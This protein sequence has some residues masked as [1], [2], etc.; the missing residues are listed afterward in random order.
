MQTLSLYCFGVGDG[1]A[2]ADRNHSAYLYGFREAALL[3][4]CGEPVSRSLQASG[5]RCDTVDHLLLSHLHSDH[6]AGL[7][8]LLQG[9]WLDRRSKPLTVHVPAGG[10]EPLRQMLRAAYL[11]DEVLPFGLTLSPLRAGHPLTLGAVRVTPHP[12]THLDGL[13]AK[14]QSKYPGDYTALCFELEAD[15]LRVVHSADLGRPEDLEP[16]LVRPVDLLVCEL[17]HFSPEALFTY[18]KGRD[19]RRFLFTH[20]GRGY[21]RR[22]DETRGLATQILAGADVAFPRDQEVF[23]V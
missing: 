1:T 12:T 15:G 22:L 17:A 20:L 4:D 23:R 5:L 16:L 19:I 9:F 6:F 13:K 14:F 3:V 10:I 8:M 11:F 21:W 18:L 7:F 2:S